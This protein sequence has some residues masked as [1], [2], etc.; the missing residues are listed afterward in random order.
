VGALFDQTLLSGLIHDVVQTIKR[1]LKVD[2]TAPHRDDVKAGVRNAVRR[3][4]R[5]KGV[6]A[7]DLEPF[8]PAVM[9]QAEQSFRE[10]PLAA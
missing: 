7:E 3:V 9:Q 5:T 10:W 1:N 8:V 4:L 6:S 2:W